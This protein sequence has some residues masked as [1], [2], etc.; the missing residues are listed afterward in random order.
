MLKRTIKHEEL[1]G[2]Y[3]M[4]KKIIIDACEIFGEFEI[5]ARCMKMEKN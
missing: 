4:G 3:T 2:G 1:K 5:M